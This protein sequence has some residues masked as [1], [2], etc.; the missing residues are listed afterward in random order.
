MSSFDVGVLIFEACAG[1]N[2]CPCE[3][4]D[5]CRDFFDRGLAP[6]VVPMQI[7]RGIRESG[8]RR[9]VEAMEEID[10]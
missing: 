6:K 7:E 10:G 2:D 8:V 5:E 9:L 1:E 4:I 3:E